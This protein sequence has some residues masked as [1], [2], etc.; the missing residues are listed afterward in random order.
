MITGTV[1]EDGRPLI[2]VP[3][4]GEIWSGVIDTGFNSY[5]ELPESMRSLFQ[6]RFLTEAIFDLA[7]G[8]VV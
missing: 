6:P 5:L 1:T 2:Q 7:A 8:Q 4:G 3:I